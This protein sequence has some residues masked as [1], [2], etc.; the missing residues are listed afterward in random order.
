MR[1]F[2]QLASYFRADKQL[3]RVEL[4]AFLSMVDRRKRAHCD[5]SERLPQERSEVMDQWIPA[6]VHIEAMAVDRAPIVASHPRSPTAASYRDLFTA[7]DDDD[8]ESA[9]D[10]KRARREAAQPPGEAAAE[11]DARIAKRARRI[12]AG[13]MR[14]V[15]VRGIEPLASSMRP[16]RSTN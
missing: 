2:E 9:P 16:K 8:G 14:R 5:M 10:A 7:L 6:S 11:A 13:P 1:S 3:R 12:I 15:E 4:L